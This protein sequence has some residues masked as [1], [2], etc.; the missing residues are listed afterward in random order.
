M[1]IRIN[2]LTDSAVQTIKTNL[3]FSRTFLHEV[4]VSKNWEMVKNINIIW[5]K[6]LKSEKSEVTSLIWI[7]W[8]L[9]TVHNSYKNCV[10]QPL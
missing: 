5:N 7:E 6:L 8:I 2:D 3:L 4:C 9:I 1:L 10:A